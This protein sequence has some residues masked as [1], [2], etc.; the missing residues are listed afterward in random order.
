M[1]STLGIREVGP[2][3]CR[4]VELGTV[5]QVEW[6]SRREVRGS[7]RSREK[8]KKVW[9]IDRYWLR[10]VETLW[11]RESVLRENPRSTPTFGLDIIR[12]HSLGSGI[13][14]VFDPLRR[15]YFAARVSDMYI[16]HTVLSI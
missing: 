5:F 8:K 3:L 6:P 15:F 13:Q 7:T 2:P 4:D 9:L 11:T 10:D 16:S 14:V 12:S 1:E